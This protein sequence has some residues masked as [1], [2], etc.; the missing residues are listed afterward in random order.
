MRLR[1]CTGA[2]KA[3]LR[4]SRCVLRASLQAAGRRA[5]SGGWTSCVRFPGDFGVHDPSEDI[6]LRTRYYSCRSE[7]GFAQLFGR[8]H[9][10]DPLHA[11]PTGS[12][13]S[14]SGGRAARQPHRTAYQR[15]AFSPSAEDIRDGCCRRFAGRSPA[16]VQNRRPRGCCLPTWTKARASSWGF[17]PPSSTHACVRLYLIPRIRSANAPDA[18]PAAPCNAER[19]ST[20]T[21]DSGTTPARGD[22]GTAASARVG[23]PCAGEP[24]STAR[25]VMSFS[26][27]PG[28]QPHA[29][30][31]AAVRT[32]ARPR[33]S[34]VGSRR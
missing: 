10:S 2:T 19:A 26:Q 13:R 6:G 30:R 18:E 15:P 33:P 11:M 25:T 16:R 32:G 4:A 23:R 27:R 12:R 1:R 20:G 34:W 9:T 3:V 8:P 17:R 24:G 5:R 21:R 29:L 14:R 28:Q 22:F 7:G 31:P